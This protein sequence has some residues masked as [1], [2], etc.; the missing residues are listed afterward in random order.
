MRTLS[1]LLVVIALLAGCAAAAR[2]L[3]LR[4]G[5]FSADRRE[6]VAMVAAAYA[7]NPN[8]AAVLY[9]VA[10][11]LARAGRTEDALEALRRMAAQGTGVDPRA[12]DGFS[13]LVNLPEFQRITAAIR[14]ENPPVLRAREL[15]SIEVGDLCPEGIAWSAK[16]ER[17]Y[18]GSGKRTI[19]TIDRKGHFETL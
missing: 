14:A 10:A 13:S 4:P 11:N 2:D 12:K 1:T 5:D 8:D 18:L 15:F 9:Q 3:A 17:L 7:E 19:V 6:E 16:T